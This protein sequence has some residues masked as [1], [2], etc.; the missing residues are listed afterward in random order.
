MKRTAALILL[1]LLFMTSGIKAQ[2]F[3]VDSA[4]VSDDQILNSGTTIFAF[5]FSGLA[6]TVNGVDFS[7][8]AQGSDLTT[9]GFRGSTTNDESN[10][11]MSTALTSVVSVSEAGTRGPF[12]DI[13][14][15][16]LGVT[17]EL[18]LLTSGAGTAG[19]ETVTDTTSDTI[20][21]SGDLFFGGNGSGAYSIVDTFVAGSSDEEVTFSPDG[22]SPVMLSA[23][24]LQEVND[25]DDAPE[26]AT[27]PLLVSGILLLLGLIE[28]RRRV[29]L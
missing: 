26:P 18:Q 17:Y 10:S 25:V 9:F 5:D 2:E 28:R 24:N 11:E 13:S 12:L 29:R 1:G 3:D 7:G 15:L 6:A 4:V 19:S 27:L 22:A 16:T 8:A 21:P 20:T 14:G 23:I